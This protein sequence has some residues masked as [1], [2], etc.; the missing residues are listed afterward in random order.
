[1]ADGLQN[2]GNIL[3]GFGAGVQG[4]G[5]QFIQG[6][7]QQRLGQQKQ[8]K[9]DE[10]ERVTAAAQDAAITLDHLQNNRP[11]QAL[12]VLNNRKQAIQQLG[13]DTKDTDEEIAQVNQGIASGDFSQ[14]L[15][16][17]GGAVSA[18]RIRG[19]LP[20]AAEQ[21][22][23]KEFLKEERK[24]ASQDIRSFNTKAREMRTSFTKME[25]LAKQAETGSRGA[26]NAMTV[27]LARL[28]SPGIV[29]ET[30]ASALSG[31]QNTMQAI[32]QA[33]SGK[34][35]DV[36]KLQ[37]HIDPF[38]ET[39]D[40]QGL[41]QVGKSVVASGRKPLMDMFKNSEA[42]ARRSGISKKAFDTNFLN[43]PNFAYLQSFQ[44][45][46]DQ[47]PPS[48]VDLSTL[49]DAELLQM[50]KDAQAGAR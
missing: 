29:T 8:T 37:T 7:E 35:F 20:K 44:D 40:A 4:R 16:S 22:D 10:L 26:R 14:S 17:L 50:Q 34:G 47:P 25:G 43:N 46:V 1:M 48:D 13:G 31:G 36:G 33:L 5:G 28:I 6:L 38:G 49:T 45:A 42:R 2:L 32:F 15:D 3:A 24:T 27:S 39:F 23:K 11:Q 21:V 41:L 9:A 18:A 19:Y 30:E 12:D